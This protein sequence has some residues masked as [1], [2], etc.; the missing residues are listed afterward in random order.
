M[1]SIGELLL[2]ITKTM[3]RIGKTLDFN[4]II[5]INNAHQPH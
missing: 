5:D 4:Q 3:N 1:E 2:K